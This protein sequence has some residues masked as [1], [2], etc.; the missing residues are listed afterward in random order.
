MVINPCSYLTDSSCVESSSKANYTDN[1]NISG[2]PDILIAFYTNMSILRCN[3]DW[4]RLINCG[5][6]IEIHRP[7]DERILE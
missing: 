2:G 1:T 3:E 6:F 4:E 7:M 5:S